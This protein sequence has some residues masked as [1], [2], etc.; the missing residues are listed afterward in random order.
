MDSGLAV[1]YFHGYCAGYD[2]YHKNDILPLKTVF[3]LGMLHLLIIITNQNYSQPLNTK[4]ENSRGVSKWLLDTFCWEWML[5]V[6]SK[7]SR[8]SYSCSLQYMV[9][10]IQIT[11][12]GLDDIFVNQLFLLLLLLLLLLFLIISGS[13]SSSIKSEVS[14][15]P[16]LTIFSVVVFFLQ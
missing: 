5:L 9:L 13:S 12:S 10:Y 7:F 16:A 6:R 11:H 4:S 8:I 3:C 14:I 15:I 1:S 2:V